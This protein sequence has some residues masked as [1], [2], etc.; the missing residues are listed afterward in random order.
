M[1][2]IK[3]YIAIARPDHW[4]KHAFILPG[5]LFAFLLG[6][7]KASVTEVAGDFIIGVI[8]ACL[9]ASANYTI[10]EWLDHKSDAFHPEKKSRKSVSG[11]ISARGVYVQYLF[12]SIIGLILAYS[13]N[14]PCFILSVIFLISGLVYNVE[15]IRAKDRVYFD[16]LTESLNNPIRLLLGWYIV[17]SQHFPPSSL[18]LGY[19]F[20]GAFLMTAKR[21]SELRYLTEA[22][23]RENAGLYRRSFKYYTDDILITLSVLYMLLASILLS[24]F[25]YKYRAEYILLTPLYSILC[26][27]YMNSALKVD[28]IA[29][30][31]EKVTKD[32]KLMT[33]LVLLL[34]AFIALSFIDIPMVGEAVT[35]KFP[36]AS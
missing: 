29:Q 2:N 1:I 22:G 25:L 20:I 34:L 6:A 26:A 7:T 23:G 5:V 36:P 18:L 32:K 31:P 17:A 21:V 9:I 33:L 19:Y 16:V 24:I 13:V 4:I 28:S 10:N 27:Y 12:L 35:F 15:P 14:R 3:P 11:L 8:A 30:K